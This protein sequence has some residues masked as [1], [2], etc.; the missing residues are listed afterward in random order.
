MNLPM[1]YLVITMG[2]KILV[3]ATK[4]AGKLKEFSRILEP[5]G[6]VVKSMA[7]VDINIDIE[8]NGTT[9]AENAVIKARAIHQ[10]TKSYVIADDSGL[11]I[12]ALGG[13][14]GVYSARYMGENTPYDVKM[15]GIIS[16]LS[17]V[18]KSQRT[19]RFVSAIAYITPD[20]AC[21]VYEGICQGEIGYEPRG[22]HGFGYDPIFM[23]GEKSYAELSDNEKDSVSHRGKALLEFYRA[24]SK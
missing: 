24:I 16:E 2:T 12:D 14:P 21:E 13:A 17:N 7:E 18:A 3:V 9:F 19:A 6:F 11:C 10:I 20:G 22:S 4:N 8:E 23:V 1:H 5:L 15:R